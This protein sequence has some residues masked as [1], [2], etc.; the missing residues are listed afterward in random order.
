LLICTGL[1][2]NAQSKIS[3]KHDDALSSFDNIKWD[4]QKVN[5]LYQFCLSLQVNNIPKHLEKYA[6]EGKF[7]AQKINYTKGVGL[8]QYAKGFTYYCQRNYQ[9][10]LDTIANARQILESISDITNSGHCTFIMAHINYD[11]GN[12]PQVIIHSEAALAK[13]KLSGFSALNGVCYNDMALAYIRMGKYNKTVEYSL[14]AYQISKTISDKPG[15]AQSLQLMGSSFYDFKNYDNA[16]KNIKAASLLNLELKDSFAFA[17]NTNML[18]EIYLEQNN[19][20]GAMKLFQES[21]DIYSRS[22]A[23]PWGQPWGYSNIG[24]VYE[25]IGDSLQGL[26]S[27]ENA[28]VNYKKALENYHQ[29]LQKFQAIK[30][31][32][33]SCEQM[34]LLGRTYFKLNNITQAKKLLLQGVELSAQIG[35]KRHMASSYLYLSKVDS[36]EKNI[37]L[38]YKHYKLHVLYRD[39]VYNMQSFQSLLAYKAQEDVEK[40]DNEIALLE[41]ENKLQK[42]LSE[43]RSQGRNFAY[44]IAALLLMGGIYGYFRFKKQNKIKAEQKLL[45]DRLAISQDLHDSIGSTLSS[46]A[47]YSQV[48]KIHGAR[49]EHDDMNEMLER[50]SAAS[51]ETVVEMNDI[52][53]A[54]N[55]QNDSME[56]IVQRMESFAKP[57]AAARNIHFDFIYN[58]SLLD[59][60]LNMSVRK[61]LYLIFKEAVNNSIKYSGAKDLIVSL[62]PKEQILELKI[63]DNGIGFNIE[64]TIKDKQSSLSG[65]GLINLYKRASEINGQLD[66]LSNS[67][68]GTTIILLFSTQLNK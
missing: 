63:Y 44:L 43:K 39:S 14:K 30:D 49:N 8:M 33:G 45:R 64:S 23:P 3:T 22:N 18:G 10:A 19:L 54:L 13:W 40:K 20:T 50:I 42:A 55:P 26:N 27:K 2:T 5:K 25:R 21:F 48:A 56:K 7:F 59:L 61:N 24:S 57:L 47:V 11:K 4:T 12:Y 62:L 37:S 52:V 29:S 6:E 60:S 34:M 36:A 65:N 1:L 41:T 67:N 31:P 46:I 17:R 51:G 28:M 58:T 16:F 66:I 35:E 15:M 68:N 53:W 38:A 9:K 32:A